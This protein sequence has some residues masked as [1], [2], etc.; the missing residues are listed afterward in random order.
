MSLQYGLNYDRKKFYGT[1][2]FPGI[3]ASKKI[4]MAKKKFKQG[5]GRRSIKSTDWLEGILTEKLQAYKT[6]LL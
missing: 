4:E 5:D 2:P 1:V 3:N 6:F